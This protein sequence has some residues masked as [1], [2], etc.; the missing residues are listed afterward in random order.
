ML[1][2]VD[3]LDHYAYNSL[4]W[5]KGSPMVL[6]GLKTEKPLIYQFDLA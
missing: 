5:G 4:C 2:L 3:I 1:I 6:N